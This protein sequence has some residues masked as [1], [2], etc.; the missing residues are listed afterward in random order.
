[1]VLHSNNWKSLGDIEPGVINRFV[2]TLF[3]AFT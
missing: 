3:T 2:P 1:M